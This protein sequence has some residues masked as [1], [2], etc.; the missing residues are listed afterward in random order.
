MEESGKQTR[1]T[2]TGLLDIQGN[3]LPAGQY[4]KPKA[5]LCMGPFTVGIEPFP[6]KMA[7]V[8]AWINDVLVDKKVVTLDCSEASIAG[9][10]NSIRIKV[11]FK[12]DFHTRM[13]KIL[14][15]SSIGSGGV[16]ECAIYEQVWGWGDVHPE[17]FVALP[18]S[19]IP[20]GD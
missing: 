8:H 12:L 19:D 15:E 18:P 7:V 6:S 11:I 1:R 2:V 5:L 14:A 10:V 13:A 9:G 3:S 16:S 20:C 4:N 17:P